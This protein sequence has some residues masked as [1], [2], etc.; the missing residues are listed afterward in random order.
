MY[1]DLSLRL[2][3]VA[4]GHVSPEQMVEHI[5]RIG[6]ER[7]LY[8]SNFC[9][10]EMLHPDLGE[11]DTVEFQMSQTAKGLQVLATLPLTD[12]ERA[13]IAGR[14]FRRCVGLDGVEAGLRS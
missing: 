9:L 12:D 10:N 14:N 13:D 2:P 11:V 4:D 6:A 8:G 1:G 7:L 5:R 3:E